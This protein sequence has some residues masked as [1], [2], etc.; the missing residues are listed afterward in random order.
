VVQLGEECDDANIVNE[1]ACLNSCHLARCGDSVVHEGVEECDDGN[2]SN[3]DGCLNSCVPAECGDGY[4]W[5]G[6][7]ECDDGNIESGDWCSAGCGRCYF[8]IATPASRT[9]ARNTCEARDSDLV[10][11]NSAAENAHVK[12]LAGSDDVW[13]GLSISLCGD[14]PVISW[15][16]G[17][18]P[19]YQNWADG[20]PSDC[21]ARTAATLSGASTAGAW[22]ARAWAG[23]EYPFI[24][25]HGY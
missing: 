11:I 21:P 8:L 6:V 12:S 1:D 18:I 17:D 5:R 23:P 24:C 16:G 22:Y 15:D 7:E 14:P 25:E 13:I 4:L 10:S 19:S 9:F 20:E 2:V 3:E